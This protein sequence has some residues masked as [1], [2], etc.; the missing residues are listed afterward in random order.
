MGIETGIGQINTRMLDHVS[1]LRRSTL[2]KTATIDGDATGIEVYGRSKEHAAYAYTG[3]LNLQAHVHSWE[4]TGIPVAAELLGGTEDPHTTCV[5]QLY[6]PL[7]HCPRKCSKFSAAMMLAT[8]LPSWPKPAWPIPTT[9]SS[10]LLVP[11]AML[12]SWPPPK[13]WVVII[14]FQ[15]W[16]WTTPKSQSLT[17]CWAPGR[18][19]PILSA[20]LGAPASPLTVFLLAGRGNAAPS[21][22]TS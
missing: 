6:R 3:A 17:T 22:K 9:I 7:L 14:G 15:P 2:L 21:P 4:E 1:L 10:L 8:L 13:A 20:L 12:R 18:L 19:M 11:D 5:A 16:A